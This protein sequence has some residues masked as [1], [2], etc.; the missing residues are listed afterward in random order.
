MSATPA[1]AL[2]AEQIRQMVA[3]NAYAEY[4]G[5]IT[6]SKPFVSEDGTVWVEATVP[7][8][9]AQLVD[10]FDTSG[11][12]VDRLRLPP[13]RRLLGVGR[14]ALYLVTTDDDG[15]ERLERYAWPQR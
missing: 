6:G 9:A 1:S 11:R 10:V 14:K 12:R 13:H 8:G 7:F 4:K 15:L 5:P 3:H 2:E